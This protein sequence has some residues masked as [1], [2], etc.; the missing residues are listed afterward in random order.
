MLGKLIK[1]RAGRRIVVT[2][3][4]AL[5]VISAI[6]LY[7]SR[8]TGRTLPSTAPPGNAVTSGY[9]QTVNLTTNPA[10]HFKLTF[11]V[12]QRYVSGITMSIDTASAVT[13]ATAY[14]VT[15]GTN[16]NTANKGNIV[17]SSAV[18]MQAGFT[19]TNVTLV[20][21]GRGNVSGWIG[22]YQNALL[23]SVSPTFVKVNVTSN[24]NSSPTTHPG[25]HVK[26]YIRLDNL[27]ATITVPSGAHGTFQVNY[28]TSHVPGPLSWA[29]NI[30]WIGLS[31]VNASAEDASYTAPYVSTNTTFT[32]NIS[33][34]YN[35][36]VGNYSTLRINVL[37][38][39]VVVPPP[40]RHGHISLNNL[41]AAISV[42]VNSTTPFIINYTTVNVTLPL[43]WIAGTG[44]VQISTVNGTA[45]QANISPP[46]TLQYNS[47]SDN[48][49]TFV[50][51]ISV[52]SANNITNHST[53][54]VTV[55]GQPP[56]RHSHISLNNL[57]AAIS[58]PVNSTTHFIINYTAVNVKQPLNWKTSIN[59]TLISTVNGTAAEANISPPSTLH[60][61]STTDNYGT[62][63][64]NISVTSA[65]NISNHSTLTITVTGQP[66]IRSGHISLDNLPAAISVPVN[67][68]T[69]FIVNYTAVNVTLPL[70]W[71][72][73]TGWVQI[74]TVNSTA[75]Q[76]NIS[77]PSTLHYNYTTD[78]YGT[79]VIN[80]SVTSANNI[81][82]HSTL[83]ITVT[84]QPPRNRT[85]P[86][87]GNYFVYT[88]QNL[89][90]NKT[91]ENRGD[92][93][94][95]NVTAELIDAFL[96]N[97]TTKIT[98]FY[99]AT[100]VFRV[101][102]GNVSSSDDGHHCD[103]GQSARDGE[104]EHGDD[105]KGQGAITVKI[106]LWLKVSTSGN[107]V[108]NV[109][110][111]KMS[112]HVD[113]GKHKGQTK[114]T[115]AVKLVDM[116]AFPLTV[117]FYSTGPPVNMLAQIEGAQT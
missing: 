46:S 83:T 106:K 64:I 78:N 30:T 112:V 110:M 56:I 114:H 29:T 107:T 13:N 92:R 39:S 74:S 66:P 57:P 75:A 61:N 116:P 87:N 88:Y 50:I 2:L 65:N 41:P 14:F 1:T 51:N 45:A 8:Q 20:V 26:S 89:S 73:G 28:T 34:S 37:N 6:A 32:A 103:D 105:G 49:G 31:M 67:S 104:H 84:G 111:V 5:L 62:F 72:A 4:V 33:V 21:S 27:P 7:M 48:Y 85:A 69:P 115:T 22:I 15:S 16:W 91:F 90:V 96:V 94:Y 109:S 12:L 40:G 47:T 55:T 81:S 68:T 76:A 117:V 98:S 59:W 100:I 42:P 82:N 3:V 19:D 113:H 58:V 44:W 86:G 18:D 35:S 17:K 52:T 93:M 99:N 101:V 70:N 102:V 77:P 10:Q 9:P 23:G 80:V 36:T 25:Q 97:G 24:H 95:A 79:F 60:Y 54:T 43:N 108:T 63:V 53:I 71:I 11:T 38:S